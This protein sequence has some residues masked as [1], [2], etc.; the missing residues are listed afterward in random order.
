MS[1]V[2]SIRRWLGHP[3]CSL[4]TPRLSP[5][6]ARSLLLWEF[7]QALSPELSSSFFAA[8]P[9]ALQSSDNHMPWFHASGLEPPFPTPHPTR[10]SQAC[11]TGLLSQPGF[12][13]TPPWPESRT[14][15]PPN[16]PSSTPWEESSDCRI[17][18]SFIPP[19]S[20][21]HSGLHLLCSSARSPHLCQ[22]SVFSKNC[23]EV[24]FPNPLRL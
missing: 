4:S 20:T 10:T 11:P 19:L 13:K 7:S 23:T 16:P 14:F 1:F 6:H 21:Q 17:C 8:A 22:V 12:L 9:V 24:H 18:F 2:G 3:N 15:L 5:W